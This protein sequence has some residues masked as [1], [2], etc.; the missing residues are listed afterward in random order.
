M[1]TARLKAEVEKGKEGQMM[2]ERMWTPVFYGL[3]V[4]QA[5][6]PFLELLWLDFVIVHLSS[7]IS[8]PG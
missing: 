4:A 3:Q 8:T 2:K 7:Y 1:G 5:T 6:Q